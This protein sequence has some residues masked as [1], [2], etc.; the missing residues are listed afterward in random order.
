[1]L[2][3]AC[4]N[5]E[6]AT[7]RRAPSPALVSTNNKCAASSYGLSEAIKQRARENPPVQPEAWHPSYVHACHEG[8][9]SLQLRS[10]TNGTPGH[11][12]PYKCGSRHHKG[13]CQDRWRRILYA[14]LNSPKSE[15]KTCRAS[16]AMF[17]TLTL[18][19][20]WHRDANDDSKLAANKMLG[21]YL[22][23]FVDALNKRQKRAGR[24]PLRLF[25][26]REVHKSGVP[27]LHALVVHRELANELRERDAELA[28]QT[29]LAANETTTAPAYLRDMAEAAGFGIMFDAQI[30]RSREALAGYAAKV[31]ALAGQDDDALAGEVTKATQ[32]PEMLPRHCRSYGYSRGFIPARDKDPDWTGWI[33]NEHGQK[34]APAATAERA[35]RQSFERE[36][37]PGESKLIFD[38]K[39]VLGS[40]PV[41][42]WRE[43]GQYAWAEAGARSAPARVYKLKP[44]PPS[45][46]IDP[47][48]TLARMN[49][50]KFTDYPGKPTETKTK[51]PPAYPAQL[52]L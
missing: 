21:A 49:R 43:A 46:G 10:K 32:A 29:Q 47:Q 5:L 48:E 42:S 23:K 28:S 3:A 2:G 36:A 6:Q 12:V 14:R 11:T 9:W 45:E 27:H 17:W 37:S 24:A 33:E 19:P 7:G 4:L 8:L 35:V 34:L 31:L 13:P 38:P 20:D 30:A 1:M 26:I 22:K 51:P 16:D 41:E 18:P 40:W 52:F 25:W 50:A 15:F 44:R 39:T